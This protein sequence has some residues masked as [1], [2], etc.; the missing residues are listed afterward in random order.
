MATLQNS[1]QKQQALALMCRIYVGSINFEL[2][3][4][5]IKQVIDRQRMCVCFVKVTHG[6]HSASLCEHLSFL[7]SYYNMY[8]CVSPLFSWQAF[9]PFGPI[10]NVSLSWDP[11]LNKH[12]GF[13]FVEYEIPESANLALDQVTD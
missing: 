10:K 4:D 2:R 7:L 1:I 5:T 12:K 11:Q 9:N 13:A 6:W 3:E 8:T